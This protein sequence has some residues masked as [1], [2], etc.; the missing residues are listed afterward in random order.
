M[1]ENKYYKLIL[2]LAF[3]A[4]FWN[5]EAKPEKE[6]FGFTN[7]DYNVALLGVISNVNM[8][9]NTNGTITDTNL[10]LIWQKCSFG[11]V[12]RSATNDCQGAVTGSVLNPQD[13]YRYGAKTV[14]FCDSRTHACN[15]IAAPQTLIAISEIAIVGSSEAY[16]ACNSLV[17]DSSGG[18]RVPNPYELQR[19]T[20]TGRNAVLARFPNTVEGEYWSNLSEVTDFPGETAIS[21]SFDR[22]SFGEERKTVKTTRNYLRCVKSY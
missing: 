11:Q 2:L 18:Y 14:A 4:I 6:T 9:D 16:N 13:P 15:R 12:Y 19:L 5:C 8:I 22:Q 1:K 20:A 21:I 7:D 3:G 10:R 17:I